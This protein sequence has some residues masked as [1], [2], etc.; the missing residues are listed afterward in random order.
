MEHRKRGRPPVNINGSTPA[1]VMLPNNIYDACDRIARSRQRSLASELRDRIAGYDRFL[2]EVCRMPQGLYV[3]IDRADVAELREAVECMDAISSM[4][5]QG[6]DHLDAMAFLIDAVF[7]DARKHLRDS[8][9]AHR[10]SNKCGGSFGV[11][12]GDVP[13]D[14]RRVLKPLPPSYPQELTAAMKRFRLLRAEWTMKNGK[15][16][17]PVH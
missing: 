1:S 7:N 2:D 8:A 17:S 5:S 6:E 12:P 16:D 14:A 4:L 15:G 13:E 10:I 9:E 11:L 3:F